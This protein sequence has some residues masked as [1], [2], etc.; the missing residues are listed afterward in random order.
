MKALRLLLFLL[1]GW[2]AAMPL[3]AGEVVWTGLVYA[4]N[5][6][7]PKAPPAR[8][9]P[10]SREIRKVFGYNQ[11]VL[12][13]EQR[14]RMSTDTE[15]WLLPGKAFSLAVQSRAVGDG[16]Y[17]LKLKLYQK[18]QLLV[19]TRARLARNSPIFVRGPLYGRG[20]LIVVVMVE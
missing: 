16:R 13:S 7:A 12:L 6:P 14:K 9:R 20:Q 5:E 10:Y 15:R 19:D 8:L 2:V 1:L 17:R 11:L 18:R 3:Q 4:T